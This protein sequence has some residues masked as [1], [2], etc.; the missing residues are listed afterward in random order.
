MARITN[1][2]RN[3][4]LIPDISRITLPPEYYPQ[5]IRILKRPGALERSQAKKQDVITTQ[6]D[7]STVTAKSKP[8]E[9][10]EAG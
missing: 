1:R 3:G 6:T 4:E 2:R 8:E 9:M 10:A 5:L 7:F